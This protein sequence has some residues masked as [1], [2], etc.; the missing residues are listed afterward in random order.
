[1]A[2]A[3]QISLQASSSA[4]TNLANAIGMPMPVQMSAPPRMPMPNTAPN[5]PM[6]IGFPN[7]SMSNA[8]HSMPTG[9]PPRLPMGIANQMAPPAPAASLLMSGSSG[10]SSMGNTMPINSVDGASSVPSL[11]AAM[12]SQPPSSQSQISTPQPHM[13]SSAPAPNMYSQAPAPNPPNTMPAPAVSTP[14]GTRATTNLPMCTSM[15]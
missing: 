4:S 7:M 14:G 10:F 8:S 5:M 12:F 11:A 15:N 13:Q 1:M 9:L 6:P 2:D 3:V